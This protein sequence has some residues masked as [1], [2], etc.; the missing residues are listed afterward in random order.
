MMGEPKE[1]FLTAIMTKKEPSFAKKL[2]EDTPERVTPDLEEKDDA[3]SCAEDLLRAIE[4]K[5]AK[6][7]VAAFKAL[8]MAT[9]GYEEEEEEES[10]DE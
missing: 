2:T 5:S 8:D 4:M 7:I 10:G 1:K 3:I 6:G 9:S